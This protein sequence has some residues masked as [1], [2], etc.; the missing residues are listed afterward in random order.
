MISVEQ[1]SNYMIIHENCQTLWIQAR[2]GETPEAVNYEIFS[3]RK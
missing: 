2:A 3:L 1:D